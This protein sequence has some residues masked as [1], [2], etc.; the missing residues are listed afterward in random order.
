MVNISIAKYIVAGPKS[1]FIGIS[2]EIANQLIVNREASVIQ[3]DE[4]STIRLGSGSTM[5]LGVFA[6]PSMLQLHLSSV[7][8]MSS[9]AVY[10]RP[11]S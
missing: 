6:C 1:V 2:V 10:C 8:E 9:L 3:M 4:W 11:V 7:V 5:D